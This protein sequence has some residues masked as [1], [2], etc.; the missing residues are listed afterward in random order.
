MVRKKIREYDSKRLLRQHLQK[1]AGI[2]LS[3]NSLQVINHNSQILTA[4]RYTNISPLFHYHFRLQVTESTNLTALLSEEP[5][6]SSTRLVVKPDMLFGKRGKSG[7]VSLNLDFA[8]VHQF[9][10]HRLGLEVEIEGCR[11]PVTTF[12]VEPFIP[13]DQ[14]FYLSIDSERLGWTINFSERGGIQ[15]EENWDK[16]KQIILCP[17][18]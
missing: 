10:K 6:L 2:H 3:I 5:W 18:M 14:E 16:V 4:D 12:I 17:K 15:I 11:G 7:L 9:I 8:Q 13:H 1:L